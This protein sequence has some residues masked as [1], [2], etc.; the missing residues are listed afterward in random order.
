MKQEKLKSIY[1]EKESYQKEVIPVS[2]PVINDEKIYH[3]HS[4][5]EPQ[6]GK[7][8]HYV[9]DLFYRES[10]R[11]HRFV[12]LKTIAGLHYIF[13]LHELHGGE[14]SL[15]FK[16]EEYEYA[17]TNLDKN[18]YR[19]LSSTINAFLKSVSECPD[20]RVDTITFLSAPASYSSEKIEK[21]MDEILSSPKNKLSRQK[22]IEEYKGFRIFDL[23]EKLFNKEFLSV[24]YNKTSKAQARTRLFRIL[25]QKSLHGWEI[26]KNEWG[27]GDDFT[28]KRKTALKQHT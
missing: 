13:Y 3:L 18:A 22:L 8:I 20:A 19:I 6:E 4:E 14:Y 5:P 10:D 2:F 26:Q 16:T 9:K 23:Y 15:S 27:L 17:T 25:A 11:Q 12:L 28:L 1:N 21:C 7:I 24:H